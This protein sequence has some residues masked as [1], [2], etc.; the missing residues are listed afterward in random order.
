MSKKEHV[1]IDGVECIQCYCC[2]KVLPLNSFFK[3]KT[4]SDGISHKCKQCD[5]ETRNDDVQ[6][7]Y[8]ERNADMIRKHARIKH[9]EHRE[10]EI[11]K[12]KEYRELHKDEL[13]QKRLAQYKENP[14][15]FREIANRYRKKMFEEKG[16]AYKKYMKAKCFSDKRRRAKKRQCLAVLTMADFEEALNF[17]EHKDAYTGLPMEHITQDHIIPLSK[18]GS[19]IKWNVIPCDLK[20]NASKFNNVMETWYKKQPF[21]S[22]KRLAKIRQ[23]MGYK[24]NSNVLQTALL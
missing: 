9:A 23:W 11:L 21:F 5:K 7:R 14:E 10:E 24:K 3:N 19:H 13:R 2:K 15:H 16:E 12:N 4:T 22:E 17:F 18:G 8:Y 20:T 1:F 6:K